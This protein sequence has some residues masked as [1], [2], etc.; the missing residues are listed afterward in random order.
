MD[1]ISIYIQDEPHI[2][3]YSKGLIQVFN[4]LKSGITIQTNIWDIQRLSVNPLLDKSTYTDFLLLLLFIY[5]LN[6]RQV[7]QDQDTLHYN[8]QPLDNNT[9]AAITTYN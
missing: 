5:F 9:L 2:N 3:I 1:H 4:H 8:E 7:R 6:E